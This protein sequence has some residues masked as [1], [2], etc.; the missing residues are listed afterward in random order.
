MLSKVTL[1]LGMVLLSANTI[2][3][4]SKNFQSYLNYAKGKAY[5]ASDAQQN[6]KPTETFKNYNPHPSE[7]GYYGN[8]RA[9]KTALPG[10][11]IARAKSDD[12]GKA[13]DGNFLTRPQYEV[14]NADPAISQAKFVQQHSYNIARGISD[15]YVDCTKKDFCKITYSNQ[16]CVRSK[17]FDLS[18]HQ[19][20]KVTTYKPPVPENC[21]HILV[22]RGDDP[23]P[24]GSTNISNFTIGF[25]WSKVAYHIY[26]APG[27]DKDKGCYVD[28]SFHVEHDRTGHGSS[29][30]MGAHDAKYHAHAQA[31]YKN[32]HGYANLSVQAGGKTVAHVISNSNQVDHSV[33]LDPKSNTLYT[34]NGYNTG[35]DGGDYGDAW[36]I[37]WAST[38]SDPKPTIHTKWVDDCDAL[39]PWIHSDICTQTKNVCTEGKSTKII[40]NV[41][42]TE[43]CWVREQD[44]FCGAKDDGSCDALKAK[45]C[46]ELSSTCADKGAEQCLHF[47]EVWQCPQKTCTGHG[48]QCGANFYCMDGKCDPPKPS[49]MNK[50]DF[51]K[52]IAGMAAV[53]GAAEDVKK[54]QQNIAI[55]TGQ[56]LQCRKDVVGF[57]NCCNNSGWGKDIKLGHCSDQEK[58]LGKAREDQRAYGLGTKCV[59]KAAGVCLQHAEVFCTFDSRLAADTQIQGRLGQLGIDMGSA[60]HSNCRGLSVEELQRIDFGK[61]D[62]S[63]IYGD[64]DSKLNFPN[65]G[66][67][68]GDINKRIHDFYNR[69]QT[70]PGGNK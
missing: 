7:S 20:L 62:L 50:Q 49:Q 53:N 68:Q 45:G 32:N 40:G 67:T 30:F 33:E 52:A 16:N 31:F 4:E 70:V 48:V 42:V 58:K 65:S 6:F 38:P 56:A 57:A 9:E 55:F 36:S 39:T 3:G 24:K 2:A 5:M 18:C 35:F 66:K 43:D 59:T 47:N 21:Q 8:G 22:L 17:Q 14:N 1:A 34:L 29:S 46:S 12:A 26:L 11:G 64:I 37:Y 27:S 10:A 23:L 60:E 61:M 41:P 44:Y 28:G 54:Q 13:V 19:V 63:N 51:N 25:L 69:G 15:Q